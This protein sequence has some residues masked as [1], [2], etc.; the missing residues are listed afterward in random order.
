MPQAR[1]GQGQTLAV[2]LLISGALSLVVLTLIR[3]FDTSRLTSMASNSSVPPRCTSS[4]PDLQCMHVHDVVNI[5]KRIE[6]HA[7][8]SYDLP[9]NHNE[10][11]PQTPCC[12]SKARFSRRTRYSFPC[13]IASDLSRLDHTH[14]T[15]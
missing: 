15:H 14:L 1:C 6:L 11:I 4:E 9:C 10:Y 7:A 3:L 8:V 2:D 12:E 13:A 5:G